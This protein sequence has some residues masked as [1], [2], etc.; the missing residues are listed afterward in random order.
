M[1]S[2]QRKEPGLTARGSLIERQRR[3]LAVPLLGPAILFYTALFIAPT[4]AAGWISFHDWAGSGPMKWVGFKNYKRVIQDPLFLTSFWNTMLML[5]V[6]GSIIFALSFAMSLVLR[7]MRGRGLVRSAIFFP[8]LL[9]GIVY[10]SL[11]GF[12]FNPHGLVNTALGWI[13]IDNPPAWLARDNTFPL[14]MATMVAITTGYYTTIIMAAVDRIPTYL[15]E[16]CALIGAN[17]WQ[18]LRHLILPLTWDVFGTCAVLWTISAV[19]I[20]E[21]VWVFGGSQSGSGVPPLNTWTAAVYT[22]VM[23]FSGQSVPAYGMATASA[24]ISLALISLLVIL[25]RRTLR[26]DPIEF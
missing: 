21:I 26:R 6:A 25:L 17:G 14:I 4:I 7:D 13:G 9:N 20:F 5:V 16:D 11:A 15:F 18:R 22:Y 24:I 12:L 23:A 3:R 1:R 8:H 10:G 2:N 19:K